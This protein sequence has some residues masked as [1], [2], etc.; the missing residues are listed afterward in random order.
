VNLYTVVWVVAFVIALAVF[1]LAARAGVASIPVGKFIWWGVGYPIMVGGI[2]LD[3]VRSYEGRRLLPID[4]GIPVLLTV[5][6]AGLMLAV[7][8]YARDPGE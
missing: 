2:G 7:R 1:V 6:G 5:L 4:F 3:M 8:A